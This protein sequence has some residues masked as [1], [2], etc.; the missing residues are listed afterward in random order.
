MRFKS[1]L[2]F[3]YKKNI[4]VSNQSSNIDSFFTK[5]LVNDEFFNI[6]SMLKEGYQ[7]NDEQLD[8]LKIKIESAAE[9]FH[10]RNFYKSGLRLNRKIEPSLIQSFCAVQFEGKDYDPQLQIDINKLKLSIDFESK[11]L[12]YIQLISNFSLLDN[13]IL[14]SMQS[15]NSVGQFFNVISATNLFQVDK[16]PVKELDYYHKKYREKYFYRKKL[17]TNNTDKEQDFLINYIA[18]NT[19]NSILS[20]I[21]ESVINKVIVKD[22]FLDKPF[23]NN[24]R[25]TEHNQR[26][27]EAIQLLKQIYPLNNNIPFMSFIPFVSPVVNSNTKL[28]LNEDYNF[29]NHF[30]FTKLDGTTRHTLAIILFS[31]LNSLSRNI[32]KRL[33]SSLKQ[34]NAISILD[35]ML[36]NKNIYSYCLMNNQINSFSGYS[37]PYTQE[38]GEKILK[39][40]KYVQKRVPHI[41]INPSLLESVEHQIN[42]SNQFLSQFTLNMENK[43]ELETHLATLKNKNNIKVKTLEELIQ[44]SHIPDE[45]KNILVETMKAKDNIIKEYPLTEDENIFINNVSKKIQQV[46]DLSDLV[47]NS[48]DIIEHSNSIYEEVF[49][50]QYSL[51]KKKR[52]IAN[53]QL[54]SL[55]GLLESKKRVAFY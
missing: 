37:I 7:L 17:S 20:D 21:A 51:V 26:K 49:K 53:E 19:K 55:D 6:E 12:R 35:N 43:D 28:S 2:S 1:I 14:D 45:A 50:L 40:V 13:F 10:P 29:D 46:V 18:Q 16:F 25:L 9:Y 23:V 47:E 34:E 32:T 24:Y 8:I 54:L 41:L 33:A 42:F 30:K 11:H 48:E 38:R 52:D 27:S 31:E 4:N 39:V 15:K 22:D 5:S 36:D 3:F 44:E